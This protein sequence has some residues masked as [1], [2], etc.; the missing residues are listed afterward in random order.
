[1][2]DPA[3]TKPKDGVA[4]TG[5]YLAFHAALRPRATALVGKDRSLTFAELQERVRAAAGA[6][7][8]SGLQPGDLACVEW[9]GLIDHMSLLLALE[10]LGVASATFLPDA[11]Q[12]DHAEMLSHADLILVDRFAAD[13]T[14]PSRRIEGIW[15][16]RSNDVAPPETPADPR[17]VYRMVTSSGTT[18]APKVIAIT[19]G[20]TEPRLDVIQWMVGF[21]TGSR[22][23][24]S[25][26][27][28]FQGAQFQ[29]SAC[30]RAGGTSIHV[31]LGGFW[32][33]LAV[34]EATHTAVLP[35]HFTTL[36][37]E[38]TIRALPQGL[39]VT[40]YGGA[41]PDPIRARLL[42][43]RPDIRL[44]ETYA[45][46]ELG[47]IAI[48]LP[49]GSHCCCPG[50]EVQ[51]VDADHTPL[52]VGEEGTVRIRKTG[53]VA[54][55]IYNP[56]ATTEKFHDGWFYPGDIGVQ[57]EAGRFRILGRDDSLLNVGGL[58]FPA[59][60]YERK[61]TALAE[62]EDACVLARPNAQ[63]E[64]EAWVALVSEADLPFDAVAEL[65][66]STLPELIGR[67][68]IFTTRKIPRTASGKIQRQ[69]VLDALNR[70]DQA[71]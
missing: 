51:I 43:L 44:F 5:D 17:A 59:E 69:K 62:F 24:H 54:G 12:Q 21:S 40:S 20:Q 65:V 6:L 34:L 33:N 35:F 42:E 61:L 25:M 15:A 10:R 8:E 48:R 56:Q 22:F 67:I 30:L 13:K 60:E 49:D 52:P 29:A 28:T 38:K 64:N 57:P 19:Q 4:R 27:Y 47:T 39:T 53:M 55:Y 58:K 46:N 50:S 16:A 7:A 31:D 70:R 11:Q 71:Q 1:M 3:P 32:D 18:G 68:N 45:T 63:G 14:R 2:P 36:Q 9:T 41:I 37:A 23:V 26:P 66:S